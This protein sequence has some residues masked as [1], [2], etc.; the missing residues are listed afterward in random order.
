MNARN[1]LPIFLK[2][3]ILAVFPLCAYGQMMNSVSNHE[4][5]E[6]TLN[7]IIS[8]CNSKCSMVDS[9]HK[10]I[11]DAGELALRKAEFCT[12]YKQQL[13]E[14]MAGMNLAPKAYKINHFVNSKFFGFEKNRVSTGQS[15]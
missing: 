11:R 5:Y 12:I 14:E 3:C 4:I 10:K 1:K 2:I 9:E 8:C 6:K 13:I 7:H 15:N